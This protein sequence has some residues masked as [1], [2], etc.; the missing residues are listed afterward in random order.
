MLKAAGSL[1]KVGRLADRPP[2]GAE[3]PIPGSELALHAGKKIR[4]DQVEALKKAGVEAVELVEHRAR[5][6]VRGRRRDR[7]G[8]G[9]SHPRGERGALRARHRDGAGEERRAHRDLLPREGRDRSGA[10]AD[11]EEGSD[12]EARRGADRDLPPPAAGRSADA[13]QLAQPVRE[14]VLQR[15]EVRLLARRPAE[16]EHQ[17]EAAARRSTRRCCTRPTSTRSSGTC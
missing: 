17:A 16:A 15:A 10:V 5:R 13:R 14:H 6:R 1:W 9:R 4:R 2:V 11:A 8:D 3:F 12:P 7:P